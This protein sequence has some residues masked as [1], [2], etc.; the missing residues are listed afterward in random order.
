MNYGMQAWDDSGALP[1]A[2]NLLLFLPL[3]TLLL[4]L[5]VLSLLSLLSLL[6]LLPLLLRYQLRPRVGSTTSKS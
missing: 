5:S 6:P 1:I 4:L 2:S 3:L